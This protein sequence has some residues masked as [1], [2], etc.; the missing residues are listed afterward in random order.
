M[1]KAEIP[2]LSASQLSELI[3]NRSVSPVEAVEAYLDRIDALNGRLYAY[4]TVTREEAMQ[5]A[6]ESGLALDRGEYRG[7]MHGVPVAVKDQ[8]NTSGIRTTSGTPIF[9]DFVPDEDA[10]VVAKLKA[11]GAILL[12]KLNM[13]EFGTTSLSHAFD[14]ARNPWD[15]E[16]FTGGSSSGSGGA[17]AAFL[18]A[19]SLGEDTGGSVRGPAS[20]C[21]LVGLRPTWGRVSRHGLRPGMWSMDT[22]GPITRTVEDCAITLQAIAGHDP[23]D[24]YT[25]DVPV[26]DYRAALDGN[27]AGKKIGVIKELLYA[28]VVEPEVRD[29]VSNAANALAELG[30][31][32]EEISI[33]L[34]SHSNTISTVLRVEAPTNYRELIRNRLQEINHDNRIAYLTWSLTPGLAYYKALKL[35]ALLRQQVLDALTEMD[36]LLMPTMGIAAPKIEP[37]PVIDSKEK[38]NRNR[39]GLTTSFSLASSPAVSI[40]CGFTSDNLPIGLQIG[41]KPFDEQTVL[42]VAY[43]YQ[44]STDWHTRRP[45]I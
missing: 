23:K 15:L 36:V 9:G 3:K 40:C 27:L 20:W 17:T 45:P 12:G 6:H 31:H 26:P 44:Q 43:A 22:V 25:W 42:N 13:T 2:F 29:A 1:D 28:D 32:V 37:D 21:G 33:P 8:L 24:P 34:T 7:P 16:R 5:D 35:R 14:T 39:S 38:T 10:T 4:L 18:C 11:A 30:A 19:A 41:G